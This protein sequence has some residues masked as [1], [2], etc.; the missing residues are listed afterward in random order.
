MFLKKKPR[1][2]DSELAKTGMIGFDSETGELRPLQETPKAV[3][4]FSPI[5]AAGFPVKV[6]AAEKLAEMYLENKK[7][8]REQ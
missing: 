5:F 4:V 7:K 6:R 1:I 2:E 8:D 3:D